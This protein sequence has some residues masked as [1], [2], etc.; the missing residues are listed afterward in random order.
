MKR[1]AFRLVLALIMVLVLVPVTASTVSAAPT[2]KCSINITNVYSG[3]LSC[4]LSW[5]KLRVDWFDFEVFKKLNSSSS[6]ELVY[7]SGNYYGPDGIVDKVLSGWTTLD[8]A[9]IDT[10]AGHSYMVQINLYGLRDRLI[11][12]FVSPYYTVS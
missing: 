8:D 2:P 12:S 1:N 5:N 4:N 6:P 3:Y 11:G 9:D 7:T 10:V